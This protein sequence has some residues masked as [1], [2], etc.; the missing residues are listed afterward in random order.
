MKYILLL[1]LK[2]LLAG[3][4][5]YGLLYLGKREQRQV[6]LVWLIM[7]PLVLFMF[8]IISK[9]KETGVRQYWTPLIEMD[10]RKADDFRS[11]TDMWLIPDNYRTVKEGFSYNKKKQAASALKQL[12]ELCDI[13]LPEGELIR[14][15]DERGGLQGDGVVKIAVRFRDNTIAEKLAESSYWHPLPMD[16]KLQAYFM[17]GHSIISEKIPAANGY[18]LYGTR[19]FGK[20]D[21]YRKDTE[22]SFAEGDYIFAIYD[23]D[24]FTMYYWTVKI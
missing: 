10:V 22:L 18:F 13:R 7:I 15:S 11:D 24:S 3:G 20:Y 14:F 5:L 16:L 2:I 8:P 23:T 21:V 4:S 1:I 6:R 9:D 17:E 12:G 19:N